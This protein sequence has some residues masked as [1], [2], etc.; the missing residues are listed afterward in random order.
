[1][2]QAPASPR[3][4]PNGQMCCEDNVSRVCGCPEL[5]QRSVTSC[6]SVPI[7]NESLQDSSRASLIKTS[8]PSSSAA[9]SDVFSETGCF[10]CLETCWDPACMASRTLKVSR[11]AA[12]TVIA[13]YC[14]EEKNILVGFWALRNA[15]LGHSCLST[16]QEQV[17]AEAKVENALAWV[18]AT[19]GDS[20]GGIQ[21]DTNCCRPINVMT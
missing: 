5:R 8:C 15:D 20:S 13:S 16:T 11:S 9:F 4:T 7:P 18:P 10:L 14:G 12:E 6:C 21:L 19:A 2:I 1:M 3:A 17:A